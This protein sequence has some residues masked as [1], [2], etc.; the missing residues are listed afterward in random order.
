[1][2]SETQSSSH[3]VDPVALKNRS[4]KSKKHVNGQITYV[5]NRAWRYPME[6]EDFKEHF[7]DIRWGSEQHDLVG[8]KLFRSKSSL[9]QTAAFAR[10]FPRYIFIRRAIKGNRG[11]HSKRRLSAFLRKFGSQMKAYE[12]RERLK[13]LIEEEE[14]KE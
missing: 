5:E 10:F 13:E 1:M 8:K 11:A 2:N 6:P 14:G 3:M 4:K 12:K 7:P 9:I